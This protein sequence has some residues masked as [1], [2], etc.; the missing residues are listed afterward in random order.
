M[1]PS[2]GLALLS[3]RHVWPPCQESFP[4]IIDT[5]LPRPLSTI[6]VAE[7]LARMSGLWI[8]THGT[9]Q[10]ADEFALTPTM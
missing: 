9:Y 6:R 5:N 4:Q 7:N 10:T 2:T 1:E 3:V 8:R